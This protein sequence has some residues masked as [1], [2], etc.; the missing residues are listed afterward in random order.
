[1]TV[2]GQRNT[3]DWSTPANFDNQLITFAAHGIGAVTV[4]KAGGRNLL[5]EFD[6]SAVAD[7]DRQV[8][9]G[10]KA[11][12]QVLSVIT[13]EMH[14]NFIFS[15]CRQS[16]QRTGN[17]VGLFRIRTRGQSGHQN[18]SQHWGAHKA[19]DCQFLLA[20]ALRLPL[21]LLTRALGPARFLVFSA[22]PAYSST[23]RGANV[24]SIKASR[25]AAR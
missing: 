12:F 7:H 24:G 13:G 11:H 10:E 5:W 16:C 14:P 3:V 2:I 19:S 17:P 20:G 4:N 6:G 18:Q 15:F 9:H 25:G 22:L 8:L 21:S 23:T 1:C